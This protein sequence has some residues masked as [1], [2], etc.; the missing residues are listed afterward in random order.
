L[1]SAVL[2]VLLHDSDILW[3]QLYED[4]KLLDQYNSM[5]GYWSGSANE[6][7]HG[8][9]AAKLCAAFG[10]KEPD[11]V[12]RILRA[13]LKEYPDAIGRHADL[14]RVLGLPDFAVGYGFEGISKG[15]LPNGLS[16]ESMI[17]SKA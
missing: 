2:A 15:Y 5:P 10:C 13:T 3:Y 9:D 12:E 4:G 14:V 7:P 16:T 11:A 1:R 17:A 6:P 8:G